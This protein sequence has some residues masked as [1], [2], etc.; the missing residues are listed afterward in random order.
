MALTQPHQGAVQN[1]H[2]H[3]DS[4]MPLSTALSNVPQAN[5]L[6]VPAPLCEL[7]HI[8]K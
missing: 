2:K 1:S 6:S 3:T 8:P 7:P 4:N 5:S